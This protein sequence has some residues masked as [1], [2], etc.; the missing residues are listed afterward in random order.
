MGAFLLALIGLVLLVLGARLFTQA[1]PAKLAVG[2]KKGSGLALLLG[3]V[4]LALLGR[5]TFAVPVGLVGFSLL[6]GGRNPFAGMGSRTSR[7]PGQT[8]S[9]RSPWLEMT[10]DHDT[11]DMKGH[12]LRGHHAG[13][14]LEMMDEEALL[15]LLAELDDPESRQ[16]L[17][18]YLDRRIAGWREDG[19]ADFGAGQGGASGPSGDGPMSEEEAYQVL[20]V[21]PGADESEIRRAH[22]E[23][24]LKMHPDRGGSNYLAA[25]INEAKEFLLSKHGRR[26]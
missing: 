15:D 12:V 10:L 13:E 25:K 17:E 2:F 11:G 1:N 20:G 18:A 7:S 3:A 8:S 22:R 21:A 23:L 19:D 9:V 14:A 5:W 16:L 24:M 6:G 26:S 4:V